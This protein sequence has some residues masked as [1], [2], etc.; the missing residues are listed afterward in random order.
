VLFDTARR[1]PAN[2]QT[3]GAELGTRDGGDVQLM[4][5]KSA[6]RMTNHYDSLQNIDD[7]EDHNDYKKHCVKPVAEAAHR[8]SNDRQILLS[9]I[10]Q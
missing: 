7:D 9:M 4:M 2:R 3:K 10:S 6:T 1:Q 5:R 8:A